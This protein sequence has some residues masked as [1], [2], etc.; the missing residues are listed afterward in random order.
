MSIPIVNVTVVGS[1][2]KPLSQSPSPLLSLPLPLF[3]L[4]SLRLKLCDYVQL[5]KKYL[6]GAEVS[7]IRPKL[8]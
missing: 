1:I 8:L 6:L 5:N 2:S 7:S 4:V 3:V